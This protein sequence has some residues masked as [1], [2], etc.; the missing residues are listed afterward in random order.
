MTVD[1]IG[2]MRWV[3]PSPH[4]DKFQ[5]SGNFIRAQNKPSFRPLTGINFNIDGLQQTKHDKFPSPLGD[6]FQRTPEDVQALYNRF[7]SPLGDKFQPEWI[8]VK[9]RLPEFPSPLGDK[10]QPIHGE[11]LSTAVSRFRPLT[12]INFNQL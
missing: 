4:E 12:G 9:D 2:G 7:P 5:H 3:F 6:K 11:S 1:E 10:F 8:S